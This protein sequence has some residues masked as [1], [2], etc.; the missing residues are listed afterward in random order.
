MSTNTVGHRISPSLHT[1]L[2]ALGSTQST[3]FHL[4]NNT[5]HEFTS[6]PIGSGAILPAGMAPSEI[7][8]FNNSANPLLVYPPMGGTINAGTA[9]LSVSLAAGNGL[10]YWAS[11]PSNWYSI[12]SVSSASATVPGGTSGQ[13]QYDNAGSFGGFTASGDA[14]INTTTGAVT[15]TKT[16]GTAF[17]PSATTDTTNASNISSGTLPAAQMPALTGA[18]VTTS[19]STATTFGTIATKSVL[20]NTTSGTAAPAGVT[21]SALIDSAID[22]TQGDVLYRGA[23]AWANLTPGTSGNPLQ[24]GGSA[25]NPSWCPNIILPSNGPTKYAGG[26]IFSCGPCT[27]VANTAAFTSLFGSPTNV[28]GSLTIPANVLT[29]NSLLRWYATFTW[30]CASGSPTFEF[31][32]LLGTN[33]IVLGPNAGGGVGSSAVSGK[34]GGTLYGNYLMR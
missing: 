4:T 17:A 34:A 28:K 23:S 16:N 25:A 13:I 14:T 27:P 30:G 22:N 32:V 24:T 2:T 26:L 1:G 12:E 6:V 10:T 3:A 19:G 29:V 9:N 31:Q 20:G 5:W 11:S 33:N 21:L 15:V 18:V 7:R 8:V